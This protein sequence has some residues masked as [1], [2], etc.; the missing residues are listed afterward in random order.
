M[1]TVSKHKKKK[2]IFRITNHWENAN[3]D[4]IRNPLTPVTEAI[5]IKKEQILPKIVF[6]YKTHATINS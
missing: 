3:K 2:K 5:I 4:I 1:E 6:P